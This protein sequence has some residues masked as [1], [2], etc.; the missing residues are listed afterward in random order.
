MARIMIGKSIY[1]ERDSNSLS[2]L[3]HIN[4]KLNRWNA[5]AYANRIDTFYKL[6]QNSASGI[7]KPGKSYPW[8]PSIPLPRNWGNSGV[9]LEETISKRRSATQ[10]DGKQISIE[11]LSF[12][13][14]FSAG[15]TEE[16]RA[17]RAHPSGGALYPLELYVAALAVADLE[18][19][20]YH[21]GVYEHVL[22]K[23]GTGKLREQLAESVSAEN[24]VEASSAALI[25]S[26]IF[27][28]TEIKYGE[29]GYRLMLL[30]AGH[31][32]QNILLSA[33]SRGVAAV[34][35]G[36]FLDDEVN[37]ILGLDGVE[38]TAI[39]PILLGSPP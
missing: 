6:S 27:Y 20:L 1:T 12:I 19:G 37:N 21:Y 33:T 5:R 23:I 36:G 38:E 22:E 9:T 16:T 18:C 14:R 30:E 29:R 32:G 4:T 25:I 13:L 34:P 24:L 17:L 26:G 10:F 8:A 31:V 28:R 35:L 15:I 7:S 2:E 11:Q 3:Y 39:Y